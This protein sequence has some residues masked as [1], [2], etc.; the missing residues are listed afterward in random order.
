[1][2]EAASADV[3]V[4]R[5]EHA[6]QQL[7]QEFASTLGYETVRLCT[8]ECLDR[9]RGSSVKEFVPLLTYRLAR[10]RLLIVAQGQGM[11]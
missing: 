7:A 9:F 10:Q 8:Y 4:E 3:L 2:S 1:M 11:A 5:I 6:V